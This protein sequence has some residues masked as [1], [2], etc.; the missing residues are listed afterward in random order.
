MKQLTG[1]LVLAAAFSLT[2]TAW[3]ASSYSVVDLGDMPGASQCVAT[4]INEQSDVVGYC[5]P[6]AT[7]T[8][9]RAF[10]WRNGVMTDLGVMPK[11]SYSQAAAVNLSGVS[12]GVGDN[13]KGLPVA[14]V[15]TP[16]GLYNFFPSVLNSYA[17]SILNNGTIGGYFTKSGSGNTASWKGALWTPD[18]KDPRKYRVT[19]LPVIPGTIVAGTSAIP[20][21][22]NEI[23]QAAGTATNNVIGQHAVLWNNDADHSIVDLGTLPGNWGSRAFSMN[24]LGFVVGESSTGIFGSKPVLWAN[25]PVH[26]VS[27]L[28]LLPGDRFGAAIDINNNNEVIGAS[29]GE[30]NTP[31]STPFIWDAIHGLRN[32]RHLVSDPTWTIDGVSAINDK[33]QIVGFGH[34]NGQN[35]AF[36]LVPN[37]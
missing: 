29:R 1:S 20:T 28:G 7:S 23:G 37:L 24:D 33:G 25:D 14:W 5:Q 4:D 32:L 13:D 27:E 8:G 22:L 2:G 6:I 9:P 30:S 3:A 19:E 36:M 21:A 10:R 26:T 18:P 12:V 34:H 11:G 35:R 15:S 31:I 17:V 16:N